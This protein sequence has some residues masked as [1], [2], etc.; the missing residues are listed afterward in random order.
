MTYF[1]LV[2]FEKCFVM[3]VDSVRKRVILKK[4]GVLDKKK[5]LL[6]RVIF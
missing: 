2:S 4:E 1:N 5:V 3:L 6:R